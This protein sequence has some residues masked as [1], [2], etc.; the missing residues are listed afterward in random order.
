MRLNNLL[1][2]TGFIFLI[3]F[4][5]TILYGQ[6]GNNSAQYNSENFLS[7]TSQKSINELKQSLKNEGIENHP[8]VYLKMIELSN[9][10]K[11]NSKIYLDK[12]RDVNGE[13]NSKESHIFYLLGQAA[14]LKNNLLID[15][16]Q[17][18]IN[19][20]LQLSTDQID[21]RAWAKSHE[22]AGKLETFQGD[23][24]SAIEQYLTILP[25]YEK[26]KD[27][28]AEF[29]LSCYLAESYTNIGQFVVASAYLKRAEEQI[30]ALKKKLMPHQLEKFIYQFNF[31][32]AELAL[33]EKD[34]S[35]AK[36]NYNKLLEYAIT[37]K[38]LELESEV[39][40]NYSIIYHALSDF[41]KSLSYGEKSLHIRN[42]LKAENRMIK[43]YFALSNT[44]YIINKLSEADS[45]AKKSLSMA[46]QLKFKLDVVKAYKLLGMIYEK[47]GE[48]GTSL[49][50]YQNYEQLKESTIN[51]EALQKINRLQQQYENEQAKR[52]LA[53]IEKEKQLSQINFRE[54]AVWIN[55]MILSIIG[56]VIAG[57]VIFS[58][59]KIKRKNNQLL[60]NQI[61]KLNQQNTLIAQA[62]NEMN[63]ALKQTIEQKEILEETNRKIEDSL[64]YASLIQK[65]LLPLPNSLQ[66]RFDQCLSIYR[67]SKIV[68]GDFYWFAGDAN[69]FYIAVVD[70]TGEG[71]AAAFLS[72]I[73][74][75]LL[76]QSVYKNRAV[77]PDT[78]L[79]YCQKSLK[80]MLGKSTQFD[81][82]NNTQKSQIVAK[83][84][85]LT[86]SIIEN[87]EVQFLKE[88]NNIDESEGLDISLVRI[89]FNQKNLTFSSAALP[90]IFQRGKN[91]RVI[92]NG[93]DSIN[94]NSNIT[95]ISMEIELE[96]GDRI[97]LFTDG[98]DALW[99][100]GT[101]PRFKTPNKSSLVEIA[102]RTA[103]WLKECSHNT[104]KQIDSQIC[105]IIDN[106]NDLEDDIA[107]IGVEFQGIQGSTKFI[108]QST[109]NK[110][111]APKL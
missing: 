8:E 33:F 19:Q 53:M 107:F 93:M 57:V 87:N 96:K 110:R 22:F 13:I 1:L 79:N 30:Q 85:S 50:Y 90:I 55:T 67:T 28:E 3:L 62:T 29:N 66:E 16:A 60:E 21:S 91:V 51:K 38:D 83:A 23:F 44:N 25:F 45:F 86:N 80:D 71:V 41:N 27:K 68:S 69:C 17:N 11:I 95:F 73:N 72:L 43:S 76:N 94:L 20:A 39:Y 63:R 100:Q 104:F 78:M 108:K 24:E 106:L 111:V 99:R 42:Q 12:L 105:E 54:Q 56:M 81:I 103:D 75:N 6:E 48:I 31:Y 15:S 97:F 58:R 26:N 4:K 34:Y 36:S 101:E 49:F 61:S 5:I 2:T 92:W 40:Y 98:I 70:C 65:A 9:N 35:V 77:L 74:F 88:E 46:Q 82:S 37:N 10:D 59:N 47:K 109:K 52:K 102:H 14:D 32:Q 89:D 7:I 18:K 64:H 84:D